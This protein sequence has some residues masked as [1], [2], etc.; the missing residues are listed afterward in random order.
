MVMDTPTSQYAGQESCIRTTCHAVRSARH[1]RPV[2]AHVLCLSARRGLYCS[3]WGCPAPS[4]DRKYKAI[5]PVAPP[6]APLRPQPVFPRATGSPPRGQ[7][8]DQAKASWR[9]RVGAIGGGSAAR[10]WQNSW[11]SPWFFCCWPMYIP[12][13]IWGVIPSSTCRAYASSNAGEAVRR[14]CPE[15]LRHGQLVCWL[16]L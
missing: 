3:T 4:E 5:F 9:T 12:S 7:A 10:G 6:P 15:P 14:R 8:E 2:R 16:L 1:G 13:F 11:C